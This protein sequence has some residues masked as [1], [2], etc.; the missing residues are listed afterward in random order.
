MPIPLPGR[1]ADQRTQ[2]DLDAINRRF[3]LTSADISRGIVPSTIPTGTAFTV[4][5]GT[6]MLFMDPLVV[7]GDLLVEG[8]LLDVNETAPSVPLVIEDGTSYRIEAGF[9]EL[10][11]EPLT[12]DGTGSLVVEGNFLDANPPA[13]ALHTV[14][15][16]VTHAA[17]SAATGFANTMYY[18]PL[19]V[20]NDC[21]LTGLA[22]FVGGVQNGNV[23]CALYDYNGLRVADYTSTTAQA[24]INTSQSL[25]F[26]TPYFA[27]AGRYFAGIQFTSATATALIG[28]GAGTLAIGS[29]ALTPGSVSTTTTIST[30]AIAIVTY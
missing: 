13:P 28:R 3:P 5:E 27:R 21:T 9:Q 26:D 12:V 8:N 18:A 10:W 16:S 29:S 20:L 23:R 22:Y 19:M 2:R 17:A 11:L 1:V 6:Q 25:N 7:N 14:F 4:P 24:A 30:L 15:S